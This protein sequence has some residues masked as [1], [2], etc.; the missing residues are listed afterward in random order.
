MK[1]Q[2]ILKVTGLV[3]G[4]GY[5]YSSQKEARKRGL[6]GYVSNL[7]DGSVELVAEG[8]EQAL[9]DFL[10]WCYNGVGAATVQAIEDTWKDPAGK[11]ED[12]VIKF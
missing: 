8:E 12:F 10:V 4:M 5:R 1:K 6:V 7:R 11:Y 9:K 2:L 3:Q